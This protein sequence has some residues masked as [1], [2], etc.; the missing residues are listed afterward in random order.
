MG[1]RETN[2]SEKETAAVRRDGEPLTSAAQE[3]RKE[4][5]AAA[6]HQAAGE[7]PSPS[8]ERTV[9]K[10]VPHQ[11]CPDPGAGGKVEE[12]G[13]RSDTAETV[14]I[15]TPPTDP[16]AGNGTMCHTSCLRR[17]LIRFLK[18]GLDYFTP[19]EVRRIVRAARLGPKVSLNAIRMLDEDMQLSLYSFPDANED[20]LREQCRNTI[21]EYEESMQVWEEI[22]YTEELDSSSTDSEEE[23]ELTGEDLLEDLDK[24][25]VTINPPVA[26]MASRVTSDGL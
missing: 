8:Q 7:S 9:A 10:D 2:V 1:T 11:V 22:E 3:Q 20:E 4:V 13:Y 24:A 14:R 25:T 15:E 19:G 12:G 6:E 17:Q 18:G 16:A 23:D 21:L 5:T 26:S